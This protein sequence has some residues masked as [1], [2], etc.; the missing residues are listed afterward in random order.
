MAGYAT[1]VNGTQPYGSDDVR[2][3]IYL[4]ETGAESSTDTEYRPASIVVAGAL[5]GEV[6]SIWVWAADQYRY[7]QN[8]PFAA[9]A[10]GVRFEQVEPGNQPSAGN[11]D[12]NQL[13]VFRNAQDDVT[14]K[15]GLGT[16]LSGSIDGELGEDGV[17]YWA[18]S[19]GT[20]RVFLRK[21]D[22][23]TGLPIE[24][25]SF[26]LLKEDGTT[27]VADDTRGLTAA[28]D[29][30]VIWVG[31]LSAGIYILHETVVP[32]G[33]DTSATYFAFEV[34]EVGSE[35]DP[36]DSQETRLV[37]SGFVGPYASTAEA[38]AALPSQQDGA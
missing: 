35:Q 24:G 8:M 7:E 30:Q 4:A 31:D 14:T 26:D 19:K 21:V 20:A 34:V 32:S 36:D 11:L 6:A 27:P 28:G 3:D 15:N 29:G 25:A 10:D 22:G 38:K 17:I 23:D 5:T 18:G 12:A 9:A 33:Y 13:Q 2:Q 37:R 16:W 1:K